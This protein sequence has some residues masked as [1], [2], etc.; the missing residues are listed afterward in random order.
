MERIEKLKDYE[1]QRIWKSF[2]KMGMEIDQ[3]HAAS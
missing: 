3:K 2:Q 1:G